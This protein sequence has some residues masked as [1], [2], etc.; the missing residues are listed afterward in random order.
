MGVI[1]FGQARSQAGI[2]IEPTPESAI[3]IGDEEQLIKFRNLIWLVYS[4]NNVYR[5]NSCF[6]GRL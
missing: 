4:L 3:D 2:L 5:L 6:T 1:V